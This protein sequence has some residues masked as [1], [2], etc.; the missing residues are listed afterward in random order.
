MN[1]TIPQIGWKPLE[2]RTVSIGFLLAGLVLAVTTVSF[3]LNTIFPYRWLVWGATVGF[4]VVA[5]LTWEWPRAL[6]RTGENPV[7]NL[8][9]FLLLAIPMAFVFS[10]Q[11]CGPGVTACTAI[12]NAIN[13]SLIGLGVV[14]AVRLHRGQS[15][16]AFLVPMVVLGIVP[17]CVCNVNAN[18]L[19]HQSIGLSSACEVVPLATALFAVSA[20]RGVRPRASSAMVLV[21]LGMMV[22]MS[23]GSN[24]FGF[25]W[26]VCIDQPR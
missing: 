18:V 3:Y 5:L 4:A 6:R 25:P 19:W 22:F 10:S 9:G 20:L 17:H 13:V 14:T 2:V 15:V 11:V 7:G 21:L 16:G 12:C 1:T 24:L 26:Q 8:R 23:V